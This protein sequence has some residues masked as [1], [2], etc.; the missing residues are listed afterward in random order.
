VDSCV[1]NSLP[2]RV[3]PDTPEKQLDAVPELSCARQGIDGP[4]FNL[5]SELTWHQRFRATRGRSANTIVKS[6]HYARRSL[7]R[8]RNQ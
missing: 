1:R 8:E 2:R 5:K 7:L 4:E 6:T 3:Q